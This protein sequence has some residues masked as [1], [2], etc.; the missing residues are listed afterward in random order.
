MAELL[1][2]MARAELMACVQDGIREELSGILSQLVER[3]QYREYLTNSEM[4]NLVGWSSRQLSYRRKAGTLPYFKR[5]RTILYKS[6]DVFAW[7]EAGHVP[8]VRGGLTG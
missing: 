2:I 6:A 7:I 1:T 4:E 3:I 5:G 8:A